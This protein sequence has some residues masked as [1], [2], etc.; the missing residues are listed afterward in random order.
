VVE[1]KE[2]GGT[3]GELPGDRHVC[4]L[5]FFSQ[6]GGAVW[7]VDFVLKRKKGFQKGGGNQLHTKIEKGE[8]EYGL[9]KVVVAGE[10]GAKSRARTKGGS[11]HGTVKGKQ[12]YKMRGLGRNKKRGNGLSTLSM[13]GG[14]TC[15]QAVRISCRVKRFKW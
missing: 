13:S 11:V 6:M 5:I 3:S 7:G 2:R 12:R 14:K 8:G 10:K 4:S 1:R 15:V 9:G